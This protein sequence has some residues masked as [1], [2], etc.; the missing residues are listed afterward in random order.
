MHTPRATLPS[1]L[2]AHT[3]VLS[4]NQHTRSRACPQLYTT[5]HH[6]THC[7]TRHILTW[8]VLTHDALLVDTGVLGVT[9]LQDT[10]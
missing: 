1:P 7:T 9:M 5:P 4:S 6:T 3:H 8:P 2:Q 10:L